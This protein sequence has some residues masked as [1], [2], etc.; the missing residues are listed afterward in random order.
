MSVNPTAKATS[1]INHALSMVEPLARWLI[2]SGVGYSEFSSA[3]KTVFFDEALLE[4]KRIGQKPTD[5]ALSLL[6]GITAK[7]LAHCVPQ[8]IKTI[9]PP[10]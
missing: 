1:T 4:A 9:Y 5:S 3:L 6:A 2:R 7:T 10:S 8:K